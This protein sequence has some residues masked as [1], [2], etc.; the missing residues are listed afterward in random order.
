MTLNNDDSKTTS[1]KLCDPSVNQKAGYFK[2]FSQNKNY[3]FWMFESRLNPSTSPTVL[4][5]TGGPGC[6]SMLALT[7]E[8]GPCKVNKDL[9]TSINP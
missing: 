8:N 5:L 1:N 9:S 2:L 4:W 7:S 3:F 6:S